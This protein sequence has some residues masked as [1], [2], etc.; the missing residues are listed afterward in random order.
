MIKAKPV[1]KDKFWIVENEGVRVGTL[2]VSDDRY[3][4]S[5]KTEGVRFFDNKRQ[6]EKSIGKTV[7]ETTVTG[8]RSERVAEKEVYGYAT[9]TTPYNT[10]Y[11]VK[12]KL[13]F[14]TKSIKSKSLYCAG[15]YIIRF[16]KGWVQSHC[17]KLITLERY[18][19][20]GPFKSEFEMKQ[21]LS[22]AKR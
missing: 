1:L 13:P 8:E 5:S 6:L 22:R 15:Y 20:R 4:L 3:V 12:R 14:F 7:F 21:E 16:D 10:L 9:S 17:P 2:S 18:E 19:Y 11:D